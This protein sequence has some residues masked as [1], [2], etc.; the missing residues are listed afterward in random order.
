MEDDIR[1][2]YEGKRISYFYNPEI[3]KFYYSKDHPMKP[4]RVAMAHSLIQNFGLY[5]DLDVYTARQ[6]TFEEMIK[7]HDI[8]YINYLQNYVSNGWTQELKKLKQDPLIN[9]ES[10]YHINN[11]KKRQTSKVGDT[12]D[13]P[14]FEGLYNFCQ[15]SAGGSLD[16]ASMII[17]Q[18][19][20]IAINWG[21]GLHHAK[22]KEASGFCYV[23]D[24]VLCALELL[25]YYPRVIYIDIDVHHGDGV[26]EA[27]FLTNR[28]MTVSFHEYGDDF[29]PG[30]GS[31]NSIGDGPG[32][33][34]AINVPLRPGINDE[35][36]EQVFKDVMKKVMEVYRPNVILLQCGADSLAYDKL[37][38]FNL[39][40]KGHGKAV[41]YMK[42]FG[43]PLILMGGGGYNVPNVARCWAYET[44]IC[45]GN[46]IDGNIPITEPFYDYFG[47]DHKLHVTPK[48]NVDNKN[49]K[50]ELHQKVST[51]HEYLR[52]IESAPSMAF[53]HTPDNTKFTEEEQNIDEE[54][55]YDMDDEELERYFKQKEKPIIINNRYI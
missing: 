8:E 49:T 30:S 6:A 14:G 36:F 47:P 55:D 17:N 11:P 2:I 40:T 22:K 41:E 24:I 3:G 7:F 33:Y 52:Q 35:T 46:K 28:V 29:F 13:C 31:L 20:D 44:S 4:K 37:G 5:K 43:I 19:S 34:H 9:L 53:H 21:G 54:F 38:H 50:D 26:E 18:Q 1:T 10:A 27:F 25:K 15:I 51:V 12:S 42:S 45:V 23:N 16:C 39:S 48:N 32:K